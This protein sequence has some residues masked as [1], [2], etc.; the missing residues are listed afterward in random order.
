MAKN[1]ASKAFSNAKPGGSTHG[2]LHRDLGVPEN[3]TIPQNKLR[4]AAKGYFGRKTQQRA[5]PVVNVQK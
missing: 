5:L 3:K 4:Q 2:A 1:W